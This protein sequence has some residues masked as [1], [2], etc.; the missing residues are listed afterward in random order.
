MPLLFKSLNHG[1][2]PFGFFNIETDMIL[3]NNY[4]FFA[5]D[6]SG[7]I[8]EMAGKGLNE[9]SDMAWN[10]YVL[11][12]KDIGNLMAAI[13][14]VYF[15]GFIGDVY[16]HFPFP[17]EPEKFKQNPEGYKTRELIDG[18]IKRYAS[19]TKI[20]VIAAISSREIK[21]GEYMFSRAGFH[22]LL[23]YL[24]MGGYPRWKDGVRP[25]YILKMKESVKWSAHHL[26]EGIRFE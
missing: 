8:I 11:E 23:A 25:D 19:L 1:E 24:W 13:S 21:I 7:H 6:F 12:E 16:G 22:E 3:L 20:P 2:I 15:S 9:S 4:F 14:G 10:A 18:I 26:F 17:H 5:S